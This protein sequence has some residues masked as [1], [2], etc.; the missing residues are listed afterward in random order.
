VA[1]SLLAG[2]GE[3][4]VAV[5]SARDLIVVDH[6]GREHPAAVARSLLAG[7]G[8]PLVAVESARDLIVVDHEGREWLAHS[9][10]AAA[11]RSSRSNP[12]ET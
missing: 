3:P 11:S 12:R 9:S 6:E 10:L 1:R 2:G 4:L 7:G 8:E 5:E